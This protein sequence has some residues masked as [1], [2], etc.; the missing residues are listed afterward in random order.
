MQIRYLPPPGKSGNF[1]KSFNGAFGTSR[2][3]S[4]LVSVLN[5]TALKVN[6]TPLPGE[7]PE[8]NEM[9]EITLPSRHRIRN[10]SL[11]MLPLGYGGSPQYLTFTS[12]RGE[13]ILLFRNLN[14]RVGFEPAITD[15]PSHSLTTAPEP[16]PKVKSKSAMMKLCMF[17]IFVLQ[18]FALPSLS[19][20]NPD[21]ANLIYINFHPLE[22]VSRYRITHI[23]L[24]GNILFNLGRNIC[25]SCCLNT[26][27]NPNNS[28]LLA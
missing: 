19:W 16:W 20:L 8:D 23:Q 9:N 5:F 27:F 10:S 25:K 1:L 12:E 18:N 14:V 4:I 2:P 24:A 6:I 13:N 28:Y 7:P 21:T 22:V 26:H 15:F 17:V 11:C 3:M